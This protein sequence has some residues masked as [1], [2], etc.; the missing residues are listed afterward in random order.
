[1]GI[2]AA[3]VGII[4]AGMTS[5]YQLSPH[6]HIYSIADP[7][8]VDLLVAFLVYVGTISNGD[9]REILGILSITWIKYRTPSCQ[10]PVASHLDRLD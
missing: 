5:K 1:V 9:G 7:T 3:G 10:E 4:A 6:Q 8:P 2:I